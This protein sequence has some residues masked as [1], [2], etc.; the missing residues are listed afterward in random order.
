MVRLQWVSERPSINQPKKQIHS[1]VGTVD[2]NSFKLALLGLE[3]LNEFAVGTR[4][5]A[6][7]VCRGGCLVAGGCVE[8]WVSE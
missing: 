2:I 5:C 4:V 1:I 6:R 8:T 3:L 7:S